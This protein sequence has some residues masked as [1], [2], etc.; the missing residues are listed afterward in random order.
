VWTL[1]FYYLAEIVR[2][3]LQVMDDVSALEW[4]A[5]EEL[6]NEFA[7]EHQYQVIQDLKKDLNHVFSRSKNPS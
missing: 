3:T 5:L 2:G 7:F 1:N 6:P 4:I